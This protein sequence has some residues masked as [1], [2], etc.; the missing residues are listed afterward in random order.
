MTKDELLKELNP[1]QQEAVQTKNGPVLIL[2][3]AGSGKTRALTYR[4]GYLIKH[5]KVSPHNILA[6]TFTNKAADEM[7]RRIGHIID[8]DLKQVSYKLG[9]GLTIGTFHS[10]CARILREEIHRLGYKDSFSIYDTDE[11]QKLVKEV[12][13]TLNIQDKQFSPKAILNFIS[14]AKNELMTPQEYSK[15]TGDY[16]TEVVSRVYPLYQERLQDNNALDFDDLI[17]KTVELFKAYP[18]VLDQYQERWKFIHID[19]YQD[20]NH[21][22]YTW[23]RMLA[24]K[25]RNLCV[26]GDDWQG[27]YSWRGADI[28]NI[29]NFEKDYPEAKVIKLEQ[30]YRSTKN[31]LSCA[32]KIIEKN[33]NRTDKALWTENDEGGLIKVRQAFD[34]RHE[35]MLAVEEIEEIGGSYGNSAILY[36]TNAQSRALEEV[37]VQSAIP[38]TIIGGTKFYQRRE[39]KDV[40]AYLTTIKNPLDSLALLRIINVPPR[41]IG[42]TTI[43]RIS[44]HASQKNTTLYEALLHHAEINNIQSGAHKSLDSFLKSLKKLKD[45][46]TDANI[47]EL[48]EQ[49]VEHSGY[50]DFLLD[51]TDEGM[52]RFENVRELVSAASK[53]AHLTP[54]ESLDAFLEEVSLMSDIDYFDEKSEVLTLMTLH[55]AKGLEFPNII[56]VGMEE[57]VFPHS[58]ALDDPHEAEEERRLCYVGMTRA[59]ENLVLISA[60]QRMLYGSIQV[61]PVSRF[62]NELPTELTAIDTPISGMG[63]GSFST[64]GSTISFDGDYTDDDDDMPATPEIDLKD[65]DK[66][67]HPTFGK[68]VVVNIDG[69]IVTVAF[70]QTG[71]KKLVAEFAPLQKL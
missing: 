69:D 43:M 44:T 46:A 18:D 17:M 41:K 5:E 27:I 45:I 14:G 20:T 53:F 15:M 34:E 25:Y 13:Q 64:A 2:A 9:M 60:K 8:T 61:N 70:K 6:V 12:L 57:N 28:R 66:V 1:A 65:G 38:Y 49:I 21:A 63:G 36:R 54:A 35:A 59:Q 67:E 23:A 3:G 58:R 33:K 50:K 10:I 31:I 4:V 51:G 37:L 42:K 22:Q 16:F 40:I 26:V 62:I 29:L 39:I 47:V 19:E 71:V 56:L 7:R 52:E 48:I 55:A 68:G 11:Q 30:N 32:Q 24:E